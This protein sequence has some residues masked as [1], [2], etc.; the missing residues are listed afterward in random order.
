VQILISDGLNANSLVWAFGIGKEPF[1]SL[2]FVNQK[3][4][5][6]GVALIIW[7]LIAGLIIPQV[8]RRRGF[9]LTAWRLGSG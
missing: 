4:F 9:G 5:L 7:T 2:G 3:P 8:G 1:A 6:G